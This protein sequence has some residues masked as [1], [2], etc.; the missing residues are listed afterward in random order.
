[1]TRVNQN[2]TSLGE[3]RS[4]F[5][6][7][8]P[9]LMYHKIGNPRGPNSFLYVSPN[10][11]KT[12]M[13]ELEAGRYKSLL[14]DD[15]LA[16]V[17]ERRIILTFDDGYRNAFERGMPLLERSGFKA[18]Q[19]IVSGRL[20][21]TNDWDL[22]KG[23]PPEPL[24]DEAQIKDWLGAGHQIGAHTMTHPVLTQVPVQ[25]AREEIIASK[26]LLEDRFGIRI[27]HFC[28]PYGKLNAAVVDIVR[29]A[30]F[31][32]ATSTRFGI[33]TPGTSPLELRRIIA[34]YRSR[35][36]RSALRRLLGLARFVE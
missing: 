14:L 30:G 35:N 36:F 2:Y 34:R 10:L 32:T 24:M 18:V 1:M 13:L 29:E 25:R 26:K 19:Y 8:L 27:D 20:G 12:Q 33:N 11:F 9:I 5:E 21:G 28:Y 4:L 17:G 15:E 31:K 7:G 23:I 16:A 3:F 6:K 22:A